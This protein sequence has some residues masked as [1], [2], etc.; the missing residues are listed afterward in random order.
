MA[1]VEPDL[2][3]WT[4]PRQE[5]GLPSFSCFLRKEEEWSRV[6]AEVSAKATEAMPRVKGGKEPVA[7]HSRYWYHS[8]RMRALTGK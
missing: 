8:C 4:A 2:G 3:A 7:G 6:P 5:F 1:A